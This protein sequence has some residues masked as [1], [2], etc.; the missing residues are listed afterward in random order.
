MQSIMTIKEAR[1]LLG[2]DCKN[3]SDEQVAKIIEDLHALAKLT[4]D[5]YI[6]SRK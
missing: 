2:K 6:E 5:V 4:L 1:K 3:M